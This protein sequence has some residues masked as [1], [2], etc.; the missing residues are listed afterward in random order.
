MERTSKQPPPKR[1]QKVSAKAAGE[2]ANISAGPSG[3]G[4]GRQDGESA[5]LAV[6][7]KMSEPY[8]GMGQRIHAI[9]RSAA[10]ALTQRVWYGMPAYARDAKV[11]C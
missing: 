5:V 8:R 2:V 3:P 7:D 4:A 9:I 1:V 6:I 10:P 11:V